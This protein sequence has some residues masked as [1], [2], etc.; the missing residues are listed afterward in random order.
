L[1]GQS[2]PSL[3]TLML[4]EMQPATSAASATTIQA[5][6][7]AQKLAAVD[8]RHLLIEPTVIAR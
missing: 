6:R 1:A 8:A 7:A 3:Q 5:H 2:R 4:G